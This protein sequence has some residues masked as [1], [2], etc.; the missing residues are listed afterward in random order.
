MSA[1]DGNGSSS[2]PIT[3]ST[4]VTPSQPAESEAVAE[5]SSAKGD[6]KL[7]NPLSD[8][9]NALSPLVAQFLMSHW[10]GNIQAL[11]SQNKISSKESSVK[12][13]RQVQERTQS[14]VES[15]QSVSDT[16][17][18]LSTSS[19]DQWPLTSN[20]DLPTQTRTASGFELPQ[21]VEALMKWVDAGESATSLEFIE[22]GWKMDVPDEQLFVRLAMTYH[23]DMAGGGHKLFNAEN[24]SQAE[25]NSLLAV[26]DAVHSA[27]EKRIAMTQEGDPN[28]YGFMLNLMDMFSDD[29]QLLFENYNSSVAGG[30]P[31]GV[32]MSSFE[33]LASASATGGQEGQSVITVEDLEAI[34]AGGHYSIADKAFAQRL[35]DDP[36]LMAKL[37]RYDTSEVQA[38]DKAGL[39]AMVRNFSSDFLEDDSG[40]FKAQTLLN[41]A[42]SPTDVMDRTFVTWQVDEANQEIML[43]NGWKI[44]VYNERSSWD[45]IDPDGNVAHVWGDPHIDLQANGQKDGN[46]RDFDIAHD[47][48]FMAGG[49]KISVGTVGNNKW[50]YSD[51]LTITSEGGQS[52]QV[53][54]IHSGNVEFV[55]QNNGSL[56]GT[57]GA[58][59]DALQADGEWVVSGGSALDWYHDYNRDG[60]L[61]EDEKDDRKMNEDAYDRHNGFWNKNRHIKGDPV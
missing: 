30:N 36:D 20:F 16:A 26:Y 8:D 52:I 53:R 21:T 1:I 45:V 14:A 60:F 50:K 25:Y 6:A 7:A 32:S 19:S 54:G 33:A 59:V 47:W 2:N 57:S 4:Q 40:M 61:S 49:A 58:T 9:S 12:S 5:E 34:V 24:V 10:G 38:I 15:Q 44:K 28:N 48:T 31:N 13:E 27:P 56:V 23:A 41:Y 37:A 46:A 35:L 3:S 55:T 51:T 42:N 17:S 29:G 39:E 11:N 43:D 22:A 18:T